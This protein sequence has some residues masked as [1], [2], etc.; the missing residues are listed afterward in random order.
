MSDDL[1]I[2]KATSW[3]PIPDDGRPL[4]FMDNDNI[5]FFELASAADVFRYCEA[6]RR[7]AKP[8]EESK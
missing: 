2:K 3:Q 6:I 5:Y 7:I 4:Y 1:E 8:A